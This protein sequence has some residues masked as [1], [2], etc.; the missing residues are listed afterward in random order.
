MLSCQMPRWC[1]GLIVCSLLVSA[2]GRARAS[3]LLDLPD[4]D[5]RNPRITG[6]WFIS[7]V[8]ED[9]FGDETDP[10]DSP[11]FS[12]FEI[13]RGYLTYR[14]QITERLRARITSDLSVDQEGDGLGDIEL[15][16]KY[17]YVE[18]STGSLGPIRRGRVRAGVLQTPWLSF[19][20]E[21]NDFRLQ[22]LMFLDRE[23]IFASADYGIG[24]FA[25]LGVQMD[26]QFRETV[27]RRHCGRWGSIALGL[28]N[29][30]GYNE[31]E[32]NENLIPQARLSLRPLPDVL[33]GLQVSAGFATG[34]GNSTAAPDYEARAL[35]LSHE[36]VWGAFTLTVYEGRGDLL[37]DQVDA[38]GKS[39][40]LSGRSAFGEVR[41][42]RNVSLISRFDRMRHET[43]TGN[44]D[45]ERWMAGCAW[46]CIP[47]GQLLLDYENQKAL[48][49]PTTLRNERLKLGLEVRF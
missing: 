19:E 4:D 33:P 11:D 3:N 35:M 28:Y 46:R 34:R 49:G 2:P 24:F 39:L 47:G 8:H 36:A 14:T 32:A 1:A 10:P 31:V 29:G 18:L 17:G 21:I 20:Q 22:G 42:L 16:L 5:A 7:Y 9:V 23:D 30:G 41:V 6:V 15:R 12:R 38:D 45:T 40:D 37:G 13:Q 43:V 44:R 27:N 48:G 26:E 25:D